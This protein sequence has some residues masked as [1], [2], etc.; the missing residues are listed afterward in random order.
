MRKST[1]KRRPMLNEANKNNPRDPETWGGAD[2]LPMGRVRDNT[3]SIWEK[4]LERHGHGRDA[5]FTPEMLQAGCEIGWVFTAISGSLM[6]R[7]GSGERT[8]GG[9]GNDWSER[10]IIARKDRYIPWMNTMAAH[11]TV[12]GQAVHSLILDLA[13]DDISIAEAERK[14]GVWRGKGL[15]MIDYG[16]SMYVQMA[17]WNRHVS[18]K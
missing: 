9:Q 15:K 8:G 6:A 17:G 4:L 7:S 2:V 11:Y 18:K 12:T 5:W 13:V 14:S 1:A 16:L 3:G 10:L